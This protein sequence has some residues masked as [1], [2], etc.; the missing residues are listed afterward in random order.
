MLWTPPPN[1]FLIIIF[2]QIHPSL[3]KSSSKKQGLTPF[4]FIRGQALPFDL[5][6]FS[7]EFILISL[8]KGLIAGL[9]FF[10]NTPSPFAY[11]IVMTIMHLL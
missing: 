7:N 2:F 10:I 9:Y 6:K 5:Y 3:E 11:L 8:S 1:N 4:F